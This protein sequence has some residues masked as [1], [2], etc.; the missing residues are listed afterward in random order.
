M[1]GCGN[2]RFSAELH[3]A[4]WA[5]VTSSDFSEVCI[6]AMREKHRGSG[7]GLTWVVADM[8]RLEESFPEGE[9]DFVLDKA[10]MDALMCDEGELEGR[11]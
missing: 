9:F 2:S 4:G 1:V 10:A 8:L 5:D 11:R 7:P 6:E 3:A